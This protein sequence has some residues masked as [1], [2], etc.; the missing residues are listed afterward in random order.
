[1]PQ[2]QSQ[3]PMVVMLVAVA[4][5]ML[6]YQQTSEPDKRDSRSS[7]VEIPDSTSSRGTI[8]IS[9]TRK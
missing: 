6:A 5:A 9:R 2:Q 4:E 8:M 7:F 1:L 3:L